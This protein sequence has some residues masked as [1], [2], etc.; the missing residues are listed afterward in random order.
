MKRILQRIA[1]VMSSLVISCSLTN[2]PSV[3]ASAHFTAHQSLVTPAA[4]EQLAHDTLS[5]LSLEQEFSQFTNAKLL[6]MPLGPGT[7]SYI[8]HILQAAEPVGYLIITA[9][10][11]SGYAVTE[12]GTGSNPLFSSL[13]Y[14]EDMAFSID[15]YD[16]K[17]MKYKGLLAYWE[18]TDRDG[19][20]IH[21]D[22][23]NGDQLPDFISYQSSPIT[24][25]KSLA[26]I[27]IEEQPGRLKLASIP[28]NPAYNLQWLLSDT[29][30]VRNSAGLMN[31]IDQHKR[32][33]FT[34]RKDNVWYSGPL[35]I[36]GYHSWKSKQSEHAVT[37]AR[38]GTSSAQIRYIPMDKLLGSGSF[39][40]PSSNEIKNSAE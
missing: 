33:I 30:K 13:L 2:V 16:P 3:Y 10:E 9:T 20:S 24:R 28:F 7:H 6:I 31:Q 19:N 37:F 29:L 11:S 35:A 40:V 27:Q 12:Y 32:L 1:L 39:Y 17:F 15:M 8:V 5:K 26:G 22:A 38:T 34:A 18:L 21:I 25:S 14:P 4:V 23:S 36:I